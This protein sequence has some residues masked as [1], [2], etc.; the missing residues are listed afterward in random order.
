MRAD[1]T[2]VPLKK[3]A[4]YER[5][6]ARVGKLRRS[7]KSFAM[8]AVE[9][10]SI[11]EYRWKESRR[12]T[13]VWYFR[14]QLQREFPVRAVTYMIKPMPGE[15][16]AGYS[17]SLWPFNCK[18]S[19]LRL[20][21]QGFNT[22]SVENVPAFKEEPMMPAEANVRP[23]ILIFY[24]NRS[25]REPQSY[26]DD[27]GKEIYRELKQ[28]I[29]LSPE[30]KQAAEK[31]VQGVPETEKITALIRYI[32]KNLRGLFEEN[33]S[34]AE[35]ARVIKAAPKDRL[36]NSA[37][38]LESGIGSP[39]ELNTLF[40]AMATHVGL[41]ARPVLVADRN[42]VIFN[43]TMADRYFLRNVDMAVKQGEQW[44]VFDVSTK[45][46]APDILSWQES[47]MRVLVSDSKKPVFIETPISPP[48]ASVSKRAARLA[49]TVDGSVA[50][51]IEEIYTGHAAYEKRVE[52][53]GESE[54]KNAEQVREQVRRVF[55][56]AE[57]KDIKVENVDDPEKP[58]IVRFDISIPQYAQRTG[59]R[60][61]I[62]PL[63]FQRG[64]APLFESADREH[65]IYFR[66]AWKEM[67]DVAIELPEGFL[68]EAPASPG[69]L[70]F[71]APG[72]HSVQLGLHN[73]RTLT[74]K[75]SLT[76]GANEVFWFP[77]KSYPQLKKVFDE[78]HRRDNVTLAL[79]QNQ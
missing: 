8:P 40:A 48:D 52:L 53:A 2:I 75:R 64:H 19:P 35:R 15:Y 4:I 7:L 14:L 18:P 77:K 65:D 62:Q 66:Y 59:K 55:P 72:S 23:W 61:F 11:V 10:G 9:P 29:K 34:N 70:Q 42:D 31:A 50:G 63:L 20:D 12:E 16:S 30:V 73:G 58:L 71:G 22:T 37:E 25:K 3:E 78:L 5:D 67:D 21:N 76:F 33:V 46:L 24:S 26:W 32:R 13:N 1:G 74:C 6:L 28:T 36:R 41:D 54:S 79:A 43:P 17:M 44:R 27:V 45:L 49:L 39:N 38:I 60:I 68:P 47:G 51:T 56:K 69:D 57:I